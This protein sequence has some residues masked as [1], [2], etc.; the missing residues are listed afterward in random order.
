MNCHP[1]RSEGSAVCRK[2]QIARD[3]KNWRGEERG[4]PF[5]AAKEVFHSCVNIIS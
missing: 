1:E 5:T 2:M 3:D 4:L